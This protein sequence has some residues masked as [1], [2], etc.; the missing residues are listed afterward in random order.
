MATY[1]FRVTFE[2]YD[3]VYRDIEI[4]ST[5]TF[6]DFHHAIQSAIG[7][8]GSKPA[9]FYMSND[10]WIK[11]RE[12][13]SRELTEEQASVIASMRK[14]RL[15]DFIA[16]PHQKIYYLFDFTAKWAFHA[17][18]SKIM[19]SDEPGAE[20]PRC[21]KS[22]GEAPKQYGLNQAGLLPVP[23]DF[24]PDADDLLEEDEDEP[25]DIESETDIATEDEAKTIGDIQNESDMDES[26]SEDEFETADGDMMEDDG[27]DSDEF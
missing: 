8:D 20:Y 9:S 26:E 10:H 25:E 1:R 12:I 16:D 17:E 5:Q 2:D 22:T 24:D 14:S 23:E 7:F 11:G 4:R 21:V 3:D 19:K 13:T 15:C 18:L 27:Q 6:E